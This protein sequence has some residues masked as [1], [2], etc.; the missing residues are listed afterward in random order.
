MPHALITGGAGFIGSH[1][2]ETLLADSWTVEI[3]DDLSTGSIAN[4]A[5][6]REHPGFS[7]VLDTVMNRSLMMEL[8]DKADAVFHLAAAVGVRLI[9]EE[10]VRT[11]ETNIKATEL[12]LGLCARKQKR[13]LLSSTSE[14][15]GKLDRPRFGEEDDLVLGPTSRSRW[16][17]AAS[18]IIDEFLAQAYFK[19]KALPV[20]VVRLFNTIGPRQTGQY[21]MVVPR[22][23]RQ[24]LAG[25]PITVYGDGTQRR[26]FAWVGDVA[27]AMVAL[28]RSP[29]A[30]GQ[31][32]NV[33]HTKEISILELA[34]LIKELAGSRS[35]IVFV[36]Y[37]EAYE[38]GFEDMPRRLPDLTKIQRTIGYEPSMDL[39]EMLERIIAYHRTTQS[40][41]VPSTLAKGTE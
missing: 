21:G 34:R 41:P 35:E 30:V 17:Y 13:V 36:P 9:V 19:T 28:I 38:E 27:N 11:I 7:Y 10:P 23:V 18:K 8:V 2:A 39:P 22:F 40:T 4:I 16:C 15:Y 32:F 25:Q 14:V 29:D 3:I 33:G 1:L 6:L 5:H 31:V 20:I 37:D 26:S 24:A 12:V